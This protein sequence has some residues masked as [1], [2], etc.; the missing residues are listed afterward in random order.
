M[1]HHTIQINHQLDAIISPVYYPDQEDKEE[2]V[3][4]YW[5]TLRKGEDTLI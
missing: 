4:S 1:H 2:D 3:R 5:M